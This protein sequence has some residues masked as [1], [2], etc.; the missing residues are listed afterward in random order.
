M[1]KSAHFYPRESLQYKLG[2]GPG[3]I[4]GHGFGS[5]QAENFRVIEPKN[6]GLTRYILACR[7]NPKP[8]GFDGFAGFMI[9]KYQYVLIIGISMG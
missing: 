5:P 4:Y 1:I 2:I 7:V 3:A 6:T 8:A 9:S